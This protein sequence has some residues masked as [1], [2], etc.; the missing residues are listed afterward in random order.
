[1]QWL[2]SIKDAHESIWNTDNPFIQRN[3]LS[4]L[5]DHHC[6]NGQ[7]GWQSHYLQADASSLLPS[8]IKHHSYGE[9]VFDWSWAEAYQNHGL[10]YYPKLII[11]APFTPSTGPRIIGQLTTPNAL[12]ENIIEHVHTQQLSGAHILFIE[13][14]QQAAF[15]SRLF[16]LRR[17]VQF[18]WF[19]RGYE[20]FSAY[21]AT[22]KSRK[23]KAVIKERAF[24]Q[25]NHIEI[26]RI[27]GDAIT[28]EHWQFFYHCYQ[29]TYA[30]RRMQ[31]YLTLNAFKAMQLSMPDNLVLVLASHQQQSLA[32]AL[33]FKDSATL[34]GRYW[35]CTHEVPGLH[36]EV[37]YYQGIEYCIEKNL[38]KFD[39]GTQGEHKIS[40]GFEPIYTHS[41]H[42][43]AHQG[44][45]DAVGDFVQQENKQLAQYKKQ[46]FDMLPFNEQ[47]LGHCDHND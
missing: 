36:F 37:C 3:F 27:E 41:L 14:Q 12:S 13:P 24:L 4:A 29:S 7:T 21:L 30:K 45:H 43:L 5:E 46:C 17:G 38:K 6:I 9:Y 44:F 19:N 2:D 10:A 8:F 26:Q 11:A 31:G 42:Y 28:T 22:F 40:R 35:G 18:H 15:D 34:Y 39:P 1:M 16:H 32:C 23:R 25:Q 47:H 20:S 33:Y